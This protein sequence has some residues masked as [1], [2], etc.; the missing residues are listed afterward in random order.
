MLLKVYKDN[1]NKASGIGYLN[2]KEYSWISRFDYG[3][4]PA[5]VYTYVNLNGYRFSPPVSNQY[6]LS[7]SK[8]YF[9]FIVNGVSE[10]IRSLNPDDF[11]FDLTKFGIPIIVK[12]GVTIGLFTSGSKTSK[13]VDISSFFHSDST[14]PTTYSIRSKNPE[15]ATAT[16]AS[17][18]TNLTLS[19]VSTGNT[20]V[21]LTATNPYGNIVADLNVSVAAIGEPLLIQRPPDQSLNVHKNLVLDYNN[22]FETDEGST[23]TIASVS[24]DTGVAT[25]EVNTH[26]HSITI[27]GVGGG[28]AEI[29]ITATVGT[30]FVTTTFNI[31]VN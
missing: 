13:T 1:T 23:M 14:S 24:S 5:S 2:A 30:K 10:R 27:T 3:I 17:G 11:I 15:I 18:T 8:A 22:I 29:S 19:A 6:R 16:L 9:D 26:S 21:E 25:V 4:P 31:E 20:T 7:E 12:A 28:D